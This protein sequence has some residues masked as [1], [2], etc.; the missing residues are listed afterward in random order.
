MRGNIMQGELLDK[1][2]DIKERIS[3]SFS[4]RLIDEIQFRAFEKEL[5][6]IFPYITYLRFR[7]V[8]IKPEMIQNKLLIIEQKL[9]RLIVA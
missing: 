3:G 2:Y 8:N 6:F 1:Y 5:N 9:K 4:E 7:K